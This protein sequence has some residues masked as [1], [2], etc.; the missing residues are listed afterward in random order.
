M[1]VLN[2]VLPVLFLISPAFAQK[3][4]PDGSAKE[5][6]GQICLM[7]HQPAML[8]GQHRSGGLG[9]VAMGAGRVE[10]GIAHDSQATEVQ[11]GRRTAHHH[12][13]AFLS[14]HHR[15]TLRPLLL[16]PTLGGEPFDGLELLVDFRFGRPAVA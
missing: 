12:D 7:C 11:N 8:L 1:K 13:R 15:Y 9:E 3:D 14:R 10:G 16:L 6:I 2:G 5:Y 4:F